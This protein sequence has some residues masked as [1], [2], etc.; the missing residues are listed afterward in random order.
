MKRRK[1]QRLGNIEE[2]GERSRVRETEGN[3][4]ISSGTWKKEKEHH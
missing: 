1:T 4:H 2:E 3:V